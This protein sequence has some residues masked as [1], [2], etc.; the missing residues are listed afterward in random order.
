MKLPSSRSDAR[1]LGFSLY[2]TWFT[3]V[4]G[5]VSERYVSNGACVQCYREEP[6]KG[7]DR[8]TAKALGR[9]K[10]EST[11][12]C[13]KGHTGYRYTA[14]NVCVRCA[15]DYRNARSILKKQPDSEWAKLIIK[16]FENV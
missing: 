9:K 14:T 10:Y 16:E 5:H 3:C 2:K 8:A 6:K 15:N 4:R 11:K 12:P 1:R 13:P 7:V